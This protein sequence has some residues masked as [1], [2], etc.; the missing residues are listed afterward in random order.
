MPLLD[1]SST[2]V[3]E[4]LARGEQVDELVGGAVAGYIADHGLYRARAG[5]LS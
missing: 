1:V 3:R 4:L 2:A 5:A